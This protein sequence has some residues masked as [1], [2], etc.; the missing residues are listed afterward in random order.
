MRRLSRAGFKK[1]FVREAI[2]PDWWDEECE[3]DPSLL[4]DVEVRVARFMGTGLSAVQGGQALAAPSYGGIRLRR[5]QALDPVRFAPAIH[6]AL[7][8]ASA[9]VRN[10]KPVGIPVELPP[11]N[12]LEW[13]THLGLADGT[14]HTIGLREIL[15]DIW[16]RGIPVVPLDLLPSPVFQGMAC[17]VEDRPVILLGQKHDAPGRVAFFVA[18]ELGHIARQDCTPDRPVVDEDEEAVDDTETERKAE[19]YASHALFGAEDLPPIEAATYRELANQAVRIGREKMIDPGAIIF[20]WAY[21]T[22]NYPM[23]S[24]AVKALYLSS[25]A[26]RL[27]REHFDVHVDLNSATESDRSLLLCVY[28]DPVRD[29]N[30]R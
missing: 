13:R 21:L 15:E 2:L 25:G 10:L 12:G 14:D 28:G 26:R 22:G 29:E 17:I 27:L 5:S 7:Q 3:A 23:A 1:E 19:E 11:E 16:R 24:M 4:S 18:H 9:V 20:R 6:S 8:V 30:S